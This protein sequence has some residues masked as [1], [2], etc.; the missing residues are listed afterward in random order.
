MRRRVLGIV[1]RVGVVLAT[2]VMLGLAVVS[3]FR[4]VEWQSFP[5]STAQGISWSG[6]DMARGRLWIWWSHTNSV[7]GGISP[8]GWF[9]V[10]NEVAEMIGLPPAR[11]RLSLSCFRSE[12]GSWGGSATLD[13]PLWVLAGMGVVAS[14]FG[15]RGL[16]RKRAGCCGAC[17]YDLGG[18]LSG[19]CP[20]CGERSGALN[21]RHGD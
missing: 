16:R 9:V 6:F 10:D 2:V 20:E 4:H 17:G 15:V 7:L 3:E 12:R 14:Y 13:L 19:R 8:G 1:A 11:D 18:L 21:Y 5:A